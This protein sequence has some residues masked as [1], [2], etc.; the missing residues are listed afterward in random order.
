MP[1]FEGFYRHYFRVQTSGWHHIL[2]QKMLLVGSHNGGLATPDLPMFVYDWVRR[3]GPERPVYG[4]AH[5]KVWQVYPAMAKLAARCG[6]VQARP[7]MA[8]AAFRAGA[9]VLVF[10][11]GGQDAFRPHRDRQKIHFAGRTGFVKLALRE[12]VPIVPFVSWGAHDTLVVIDDCYEQAKFM[13][14]QGIP[15]LFGID[16]EVFPI[17]LGLPWGLAI[18]PVPNIPLPMPIHTRVCAPVT[19]DRYGRDVLKDEDYVNACAQK[20]INHMQAELDDLATQ[21]PPP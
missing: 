5:P 19:F 4:L 15:W 1:V 20:V 7:Q 12:G 2:D 3:F 21:P 14:E 11:G 6:G 16:P 13:H 17:Y 18:G 10:P 9:S 8:I